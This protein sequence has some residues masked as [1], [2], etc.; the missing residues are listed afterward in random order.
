MLF[1]LM[2]SAEKR[3]L[4]IESYHQTYPWDASYIEGI[5]EVLGSNHLIRTFEMDTKRLPQSM[6]QAQADKAWAYFQ[7]FMPDLVILG[8]DNALSF[9][10]KKISD[11][12]TPTIYLGINRNPRDLGLYRQENLT[13]ILERPLFKRNIAELNRI[14]DSKLN[15]VLVLFDSSATAQAALKESFKNNRDFKIGAT[16]VTVQFISTQQAWEQAVQ[17]AHAEHDAMIIGLY[18][19][20]INANGEHV[21]ADTVLGWTSKHSK[22]PLFSFWD[23]SVG[24]G[25][26][27]GGLV[28]F[29]K[30]HGHEA[31]QIAKDIFEGQDIG[32]IIPRAAKEGRYYFS[33]SE[34]LRWN[35]HLPEDIEKSATL[36]D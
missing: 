17:S 25:K 26:A 27:A 36:I 30:A 2:A 34:L 9:L 11:T 3:V 18:H 1:S 29:G 4:V 20:L 7:E 15:S 22:V 13:G 19:T 28:L 16:R 31:G 6:H 10:G 14:M 33:K 21:P 24:Q 5:E 23:F 8:D 12:G 35:I 32:T